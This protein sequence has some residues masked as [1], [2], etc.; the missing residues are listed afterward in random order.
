MQQSRDLAVAIL[1]ESYGAS[2]DWALWSTPRQGDSAFMQR[3]R[4]VFTCMQSLFQAHVGN[5]ASFRFLGG[6]LVWSRAISG[7]LLA[8]P[9]PSPPPRGHSADSQGCH[10]VPLPTQHP[11]RPAIRRPPCLAHNSCPSVAVEEGSQRLGVVRQTF[12]RS[13][14]I[15]SHSRIGE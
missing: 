8:T 10:L 2:I 7:L 11:L 3:L 9:H 13:R 15:P 6:R 4:P 12:L 14:N 5:G 1:R